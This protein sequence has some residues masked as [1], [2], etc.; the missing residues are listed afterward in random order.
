MKH[1]IEYVVIEDDES[2]CD[3]KRRKIEIEQEEGEEEEDIID[4]NNVL[5]TEIVP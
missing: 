4:L 1:P 3:P 5:T 2:T